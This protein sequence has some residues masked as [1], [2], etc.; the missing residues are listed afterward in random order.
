MTVDVKGP[1][2]SGT[3]CLN[4]LQFDKVSP[5]PLEHSRLNRIL[6]LGVVM[7]CKSNKSVVVYD[8]CRTSMNIFSWYFLKLN[9]FVVAPFV[10]Y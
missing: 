2:V 7:I 1:H 9:K 10:D 6:V 3:I 4:R 8:K 5:S